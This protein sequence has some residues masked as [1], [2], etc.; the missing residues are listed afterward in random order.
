MDYLRWEVSVFWGSGRSWEVRVVKDGVSNTRFVVPREGSKDGTTEKR[1]YW[2]EYDRREGP[3]L[4]EE[5]GPG[6]K[7]MLR[8]PHRH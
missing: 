8:D 1:R 2:N 5:G 4:Y 3:G 6:D 7:R